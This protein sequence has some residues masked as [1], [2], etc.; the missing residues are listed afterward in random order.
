MKKSNKSANARKASFV[1]PVAALLMAAASFPLKAEKPASLDLLSL[2]LQDVPM[3]KTSLGTA[4]PVL[5]NGRAVAIEF[6]F[7]ESDG[8]PAVEMPC[9]PEGWDLSPFTGLEAEVENLGSAQIVPI[10]AV[11]SWSGQKFCGP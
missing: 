10:L 11:L 4:T 9:P 8:Y 7:A 1:W 3:L 6:E 2:A 5:E